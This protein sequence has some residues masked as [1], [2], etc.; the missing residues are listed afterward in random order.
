MEGMKAGRLR[1]TGELSKMNCLK[2]TSL[3]LPRLS[4]GLTPASNM[5][6][7]RVCRG[8]T[9]ATTVLRTAAFQ[10]MRRER[11][12]RVGGPWSLLRPVP[13]ATCFPLRGRRQTCLALSLALCPSHPG[14]GLGWGET[15]GL[16][17]SRQTLADRSE[18]AHR[19][20]KLSGAGAGTG[21]P[22]ARNRRADGLV[23]G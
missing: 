13:M 14:S 9:K 20:T 5:T 18:P 3:H 15:A 4:S 16:C 19:A 21:H 8:R 1:G 2:A 23:S 12:Q 11:C 10:G 7:V 17:Y 6:N 22:L